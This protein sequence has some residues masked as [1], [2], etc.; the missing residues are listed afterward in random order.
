MEN[1]WKIPTQFSAFLN[2]QFAEI[3]YTKRLE[4]H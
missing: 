1:M 4:L 2:K 3:F